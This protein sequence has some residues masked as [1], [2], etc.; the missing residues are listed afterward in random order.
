MGAVA[1]GFLLAAAMELRLLA[2]RWV[3]AG[4]GNAVWLVSSPVLVMNAAVIVFGVSLGPA[5][6]VIGTLI[7]LV[8]AVV[9]AVFV[10]AFI[11]MSK[12]VSAMPANGD[13][14][15]ALTDPLANVG[16]FMAGLF[17][18]GGLVAVVV[19]VVWGLSLPR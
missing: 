17:A 11:D 6:P 16:V 1:F 18:V 9:L 15:L 2:A 7:A 13:V 5:Q 14:S 8:G 12:R 19:L 10:N 4:H 3:R